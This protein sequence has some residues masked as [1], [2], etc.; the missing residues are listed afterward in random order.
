MNGN[1]HLIPN[2]QVNSD[3]VEYVTDLLA[4]CKKGEVLAVTVIE[5]LPEGRYQICGST[6]ESRTRMAGM[7]LDAA[8]TRLNEAR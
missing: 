4:R 1:L 7:L 6:C 3:V 8:V 2:K 5:E